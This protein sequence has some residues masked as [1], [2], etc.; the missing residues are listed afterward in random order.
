MR[1]STKK[2]LLYI[3]K[4]EEKSDYEYQLQNAIFTNLTMRMQQYAAY[5][6]NT[7]ALYIYTLQIIAL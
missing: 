2:S 3:V 4:N 7:Y 6:G 5:I 1:M